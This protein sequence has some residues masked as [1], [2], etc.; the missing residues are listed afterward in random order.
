LI[1]KK[2]GRINEESSDHQKKIK[3]RI[4]NKKR[5]KKKNNKCKDIRIYVKGARIYM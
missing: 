3:K 2:K 1:Y 4:K 5:G